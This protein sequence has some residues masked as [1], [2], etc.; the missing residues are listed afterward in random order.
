MGGHCCLG[1]AGLVA[2]MTAHRSA[3][4]SGAKPETLQDEIAC[5]AAELE[6][7]CPFSSAHF[8]EYGVRERSRHP[9]R[10]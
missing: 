4:Q 10:A 8:T 6:A 2:I 7:G 1:T 9:V 3:M 5:T